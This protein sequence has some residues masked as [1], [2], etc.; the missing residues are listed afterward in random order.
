MTLEEK[1]NYLEKRIERLNNISLS[2]SREDDV[3]VIFELILD[4]AK[5][6]YKK[7]LGFMIKNQSDMNN[8]LKLYKTKEKINKLSEGI[9][10]YIL[11]NKNVS[12]KVLQIIED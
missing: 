6:I 8:F 7:D 10:K 12:K 3:N 4:E 9:K 5:Y 2:L 1:Y 11:A